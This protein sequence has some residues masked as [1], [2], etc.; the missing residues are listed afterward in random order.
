MLIVLQNQLFMVVDIIILL[1]VSSIHSIDAK[2]CGNNHN[3]HNGNGHNCP[4]SMSW[5]SGSMQFNYDSCP[6]KVIPIPIFKSSLITISDADEGD[7]E[8]HDHGHGFYG[9]SHVYSRSRYQEK[10]GFYVCSN[11]QIININKLRL[12]N[13]I[14]ELIKEGSYNQLYGELTGKPVKGKVSSKGGG[15]AGE[16]LSNQ[17]YDSINGY[18]FVCCNEHENDSGFEKKYLFIL[19]ILFGVIPSIVCYIGYF[20]SG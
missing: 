5:P 7:H 1:L 18:I 12:M 15:G 8:G 10:D 13:K 3:N 16:R 19:F 14:N 11:H 17:I 6:I 2:S 9:P 20:D 4:A